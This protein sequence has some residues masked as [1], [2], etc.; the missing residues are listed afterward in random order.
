MPGPFVTPVHGDLE[1]PKKV[2]V[3]V[4]G[5][6]IIGAATAMELADMHAALGARCNK[7]AV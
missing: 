2:D 3:V 4:I 5:G 1:L 7:K 6:G